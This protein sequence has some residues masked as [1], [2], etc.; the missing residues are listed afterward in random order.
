MNNIWRVF[1]FEFIRNFKR[2][3]YLFTTFALPLIL[4]AL[5][6]G[7][8][9][10]SGDNLA[11]DVVSADRAILSGDLDSFDSGDG[12]TAD[13]SSTDNATG[14]DSTDS[15]EFETLD[16]EELID[17]LNFSTEGK[18]GFVDASG[19]FANDT[20]NENIVRY[21]SIDEGVVAVE[22]GTLDMLYFISESYAEDG[23]IQ[24]YVPSMSLD[25]LDTVGLDELVFAQID[26]DKIDPLM[27]MRLR[28]PTNYTEARINASTDS[29]RESNEDNDFGIVYGYGMIFIFAVFTTSGY[30]MQSIIEEKESRLIEVLISTVRP[31][32][33]LAGKM[34]GLGFLGL[35]QLAIWIAFV[36][37]FVL[38]QPDIQ[39]LIEP[40]LSTL[41][42]T[43]QTLLILAA[44]FIL[45][46]GMFASAFVGVGAISRSLQEGPQFTV[47]I[48]MP[49]MIPFFLM[50]QFISDPNGTA[51]TIMSIFPVTSPLAMP[52]RAL[53]TDVP[54]GELVLSLGLSVL[55][56]GF[57]LWIAGRLFRVQTL[58]SGTLPKIRDIPKLLF[59]G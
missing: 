4:I 22:N 50:E 9:A 10:I 39:T 55:F 16:G 54:V 43:N 12:S 58:L 46:Y 1:R 23:A 40:F 38:S 56:V 11:T 30:L 26:F 31:T 35:L 28:F 15:E 5:L 21:E 32:Q 6:T 20:A 3:G 57:I 25:T 49:A 7:W 44:Y 18:I 33:L 36:V 42:I 24:V 45:G 37:G 14:D 27:L 47:V 41:S 13:S 52:M 51:A 2:R 53:V 29:T 34:L 48:I 17:Q 8:Q 19:L 59:Q